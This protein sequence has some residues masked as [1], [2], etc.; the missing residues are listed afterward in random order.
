MSAPPP[1][2]PALAAQS[3]LP[4]KPR[5]ERPLG[6]P[7][8]FALALLLLESTFAC[9]MICVLPKMIDV[10]IG[11]AS[12]LSLPIR[13]SYTVFVAIDRFINSIW[14][15]HHMFFPF[16][17]LAYSAAWVGLSAL[18][19]AIAGNRTLRVWAWVL[20]VSML[21]FMIFLNVETVRE[22]LLIIGEAQRQ[23]RH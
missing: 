23:S 8:G 19:R 14:P 9:Y 5:I 21:V 6:F 1:I 16:G 11:A 3:P 20:C 15:I 7:W 4:V 18:Y 13:M 2:P 22:G 17:L 12:S 10:Y